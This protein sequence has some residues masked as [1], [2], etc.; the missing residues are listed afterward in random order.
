M[1]QPARRS[2]RIPQPAIAAISS[3]L[4][5]GN[6]RQSPASVFRGGGLLVLGPDHSPFRQ[7]LVDAP[8]P[9]LREQSTP[10]EQ[11]YSSALTA[12][13]DTPPP[14]RAAGVS[15]GRKTLACETLAREALAESQAPK[16]RQK[17]AR[18][19]S[20]WSVRPWGV[21]TTTMQSPE[22]AAGVSQG[23]KTLGQDALAEPQAL[24]GRQVS[25]RVARPWRV[26]PSQNHKPR[27]GGRCQPG[28][29]DPGA[30]CPRRTT[31]PEG[32]AGDSQG[33]K[34]LACE[35]L[36][37]GATM[38]QSPEGATGTCHRTVCR[39]QQHPSS[40]RTLLYFPRKKNRPPTG[41]D[42]DRGPARFFRVVVR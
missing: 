32:A 18:G 8:P 24:N 1:T 19:A 42:S 35:A 2:W 15:Q 37:A 22:G 40:S 7:T 10:T 23:R 33:R 5:P 34:T 28:S 38:M 29:Q 20:P 25:A 31:S 16:G 27:R 36:K 9:R 14:E 3:R 12:S 11:G 17:S 26:R 4:D 13:M 30:G 41:T 6:N 39:E 21:R